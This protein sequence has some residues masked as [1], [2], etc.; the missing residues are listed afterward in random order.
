VRVKTLRDRRVRRRCPLALAALLAVALGA[1]GAP[2]LLRAQENLV[3]KIN[4]QAAPAPIER[5]NE[6]YVAVSALKAAGAEVTRLGNTV[7]IRFQPVAGAVAEVREAPAGEWVGNGLWRARVTE[8]KPFGSSTRAGVDLTLEI[9]NPTGEARRV[10]PGLTS[11]RLKCVDAKGRALE[12]GAL[13]ASGVDAAL[14]QECPPGAQGTLT[15]RFFYPGE[16]PAAEDRIPGKLILQ[17][18]PAA[19]KFSGGDP[20]LTILLAPPPDGS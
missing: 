12:M 1:G 15:L 14:E 11:A 9:A 5:D 18:D 8:V 10:A 7:S 6:V 20:T 2:A 4:G 16:P 17:F 3:L 19:G 13:A